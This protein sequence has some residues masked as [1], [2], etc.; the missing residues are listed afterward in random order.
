MRGPES[1]RPLREHR[2]EEDEH[3]DAEHAARSGGEKREL[4]R[5][6]RA[7]L[8]HHAVPVEGG[9]DVCR[10]AGD[11]EENGAHRS[12]RDGCGVH[13]AEKNESARGRHV[14]GEGDEQRDGHRGAQA[15]KRPHDEAARGAEDEYQ[16]VER[17]ED[18]PEVG[19]ELGQGTAP[20]R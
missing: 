20:L 19:Q 7:P 2:G 1:E 12:A 9:R 10:C 4:K 11:L 18:V 6:R 15:R 8:L 16:E 17:N 13:R 3:E 14:K 5:L